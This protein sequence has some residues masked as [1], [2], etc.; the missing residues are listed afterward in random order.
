M[1]PYKEDPDRCV[2]RRTG[3]ICTITFMIFHCG[4]L[5]FSNSYVD[6]EQGIV[7]FMLAILCLIVSLYQWVS[8]IITTI[9][10]AP[11]STHV[12]LNL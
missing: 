10:K 4:D 9:E 6:S 8:C 5:I 7:M 1:P 11:G 2:F 12:V 3:D